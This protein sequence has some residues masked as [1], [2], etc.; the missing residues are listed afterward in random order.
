MHRSLDRYLTKDLS[1]NYSLLNDI[2]FEKSR[3]TLKAVRKSLKQQGKGN[4]PKAARK[5]LKQQGKG[6]RPNAADSITDAEIEK[7][8]SSQV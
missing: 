5:S 6:N 2:D 7:L 3:Q 8:W 4:R 1:K